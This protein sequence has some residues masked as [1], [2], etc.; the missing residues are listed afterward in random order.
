MADTIQGN[1]NHHENT[2]TSL[3]QRIAELEIEL[4]QTRM[5]MHS[6]VEE[7]E[8]ATEELQAGSEL[9]QDLN[10]AL[11]A[12]RDELQSKNEKVTIINTEL[13]ERNEQLNNSR[14]YTEEIFNTIHDPLIIL[15]K[16]LKVIRATDGF[17]QTFKVTKEETE[18]RFLYDLGN[19]QWDI[20]VLRRQLEAVLPEQGFF[21]A[22]EVDHVFEYVGRKIMR[23]TARQFD[24]NTDGKL[25]LL[26]I[27]DLT[28]NRKIQEGLAEVERLLEES[29]E[30]LHFAIESAGIGTWDFNPLTKELIWDN[31]CKE[32]YGLK[33]ADDVGYDVYLNQLQADDRDG[34]DN[35]VK[36]ALQGINNGEFNVEYRTIGLHDQKLRWIKSKGKA[37][38]DNDNRATRFIGTVLDISMEKLLEES[39][40]ESLRKK[41]EFISIASHELKTPITSLKASLQLL[42]RMKAN[43]SPVMM[44]RLMDQSG[45]SVEKISRLI[46]DLLN[47]TSLNEGQLRLNKA[48]FTIAE[49]LN[50]CCTHIR[51]TEKYDLIVQGDEVLQIN[52][53]EDRISQVVVNFVNNA[54]KYA[55][56]V[57]EIYL[58]V[59]KLG[60][61]ARVS[62][63][64]GGPGVP[65][66]KLPY[67]FDRYY[68]ADYSGGQYSGL[69]LGLYICAEIIKRHG[70]E[71]GVDSELGKGSTF[72]FTVPLN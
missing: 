42:N 33:P 53:D 22:S 15:D 67:L 58:G 68:R 5:D 41:D 32:L 52:A 16:Q 57:K 66:E 18:G 13:N 1:P 26:A 24:T 39:T 65:A 40:I 36:Q 62:V 10:D 43:P 27:H 55:P 56:D 38:F 44:D 9:L 30:R 12:T 4:A 7:Q 59:E 8:A 11:E 48:P 63:K 35:A 45:K 50:D 20:P 19:R 14:R 31:R 46:D 23:L 2:N 28:A 21:K 54:V 72:W 34:I 69:G 17:Y 6:I 37:Y 70:G 71:I 47:V 60:D 49:M 3:Q 64:D 61:M 29:K 25:T 51:V